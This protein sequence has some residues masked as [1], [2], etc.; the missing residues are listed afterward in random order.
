M[1]LAFARACRDVGL[2][3]ATFRLWLKAD[4]DGLS[5]RFAHARWFKAHMV[6]DEALELVEDSSQDWIELP[7]GTRREN[8]AHLRAVE[9]RVAQLEKLAERLWPGS[10]LD[11]PRGR[12]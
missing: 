2:E 12:F 11:G 10:M 6:M 8:M 1:A 4:R 7:D 3:P 9:R 5:K